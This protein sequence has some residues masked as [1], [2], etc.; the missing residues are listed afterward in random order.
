MADM[1]PIRG[2]LA[3][4]LAAAQADFVNALNGEDSTLTFLKTK[5]RVDRRRGIVATSAEPRHWRDDSIDGGTVADS[6]FLGL[7]IGPDLYFQVGEFVEYLGAA[8]R[9]DSAP[10][11]TH[12]ARFTNLAVVEPFFH[13]ERER[14]I[15][16]AV[17]LELAAGRHMTNV[18]EMLPGLR[19][20]TD[21]AEKTASQDE[22]DGW[23]RLEASLL[24][25]AIPSSTAVLEAAQTDLEIGEVVNGFRNDVD[26]YVDEHLL[27][28]VAARVT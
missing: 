24:A 16:L 26:A 25:R 18:F 27:A 4:S 20:D 19:T 23:A 14:A 17:A 9:N 11:E 22:S 13:P 28:A 21:P 10:S 15:W 12:A 3:R 5:L 8:C 7:F 1:T 2:L 6:A